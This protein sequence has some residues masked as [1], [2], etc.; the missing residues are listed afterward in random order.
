[1]V[2]YICSFLVE[3]KL[4]IEHSMTDL[5]DIEAAWCGRNPSGPA[6]AS[7]PAIMGDDLIF[8]YEIVE[9]GQKY[10]AKNIYSAMSENSFHITSYL[11]DTEGTS[12]KTVSLDLT[13]RK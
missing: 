6:S 11:I 1:M 5:R 9:M 12:T 7:K 10:I 3:S 13:R 2:L 4:V 8:S